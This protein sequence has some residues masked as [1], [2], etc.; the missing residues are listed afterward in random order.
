MILLSFNLRGFGGSSKRAALKCILETVK[1]DIF[2]VQETMTSG[3]K[4]CDMFLKIRLDW[5]C[6]G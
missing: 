3:T 4:A 5:E 2:L 6:C 1:P